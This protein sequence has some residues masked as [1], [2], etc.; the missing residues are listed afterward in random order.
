[1]LVRSS[2]QLDRD[3]AVVTRDTLL[4][5]MSVRVMNVAKVVGGV[6]ARI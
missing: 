5:K 2:A 4:P 3:V 6:I 1:M